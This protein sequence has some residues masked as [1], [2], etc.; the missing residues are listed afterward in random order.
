MKLAETLKFGAPWVCLLFS[1]GWIFYQNIQ[2]NEL[3]INRHKRELNSNRLPK[4]DDDS[5]IFMPIYA[6]VSKKH[7]RKVCM[8]HFHSLKHYRELEKKEPSRVSAVV[9]E[10]KRKCSAEV[11]LGK[12]VFIGERKNSEG[13]AY[14]DGGHWHVCEM[15]HGY[16]MLSFKGNRRLNSSETR[17][18]QFLPYPFDGTDN[19][20]YNNTMYYSENDRLIS[21]N[22]KTEKSNYIPLRTSLK[23][24]Y[25]NSTSRLDVQAEEHGI[26]VLYRRQDETVLT[27]SRINFHTMQIVSNWTLPSIDTSTMCNAFVRC[28]ILYSVECDGTV[29]PVYDFY[30][31]TYIQGRTTEW[32]GLSQPICNVQYDP[33]SKSIAVYANAKIYKVPVQQ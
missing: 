8:E 28:A 27:V 17:A 5:T 23:P 12:P 2:I 1:I 20:V 11:S 19:M 22:L 25:A 4:T 26:W 33:N 29:T 10:L 30:S 6:Q 13:C 31:H 24:L 21:Y 15:S 14:L 18:V 9:K 32:E 3:Q 16:T 7:I